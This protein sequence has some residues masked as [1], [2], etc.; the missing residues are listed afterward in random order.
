MIINNLAL[1]VNDM[2]IN[3]YNNGIKFYQIMLGLL[4][5]NFI[6]YLLCKIISEAKSV[7]FY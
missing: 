2:I 4:I 7:K 1:L 6:V 3:L 5:F